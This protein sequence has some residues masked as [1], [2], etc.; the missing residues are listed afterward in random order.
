MV[1]LDSINLK[2][3]KGFLRKNNLEAA[4]GSMNPEA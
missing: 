1:K 2:E 4:M 3:G